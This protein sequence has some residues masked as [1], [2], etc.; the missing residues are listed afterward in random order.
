MQPSNRNWDGWIAI[1]LIALLVL[2]R[3]MGGG[4]ILAPATGPR[5]VVVVAESADATPAR[6]SMLLDL[7]Q[8]DWGKSIYRKYDP[9]HA[10]ASQYTEHQS[11]P[12]LHIGVLGSDGKSITRLI[13]SGPLPSSADEVVKQWK[14]AGGE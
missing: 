9:D 3:I 10:G 13:Y 1:A 12:A 8:R 14:E 5:A 6:D 4:G 2:P 7:R 11:P